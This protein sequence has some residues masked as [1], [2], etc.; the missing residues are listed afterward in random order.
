MG[1]QPVELVAAG[2][3]AGHRQREARGSKRWAQNR[4]R[5]LS[6]YCPR[7][8]WPGSG[9]FAGEEALRACRRAGS[10]LSF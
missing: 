1:S 9:P 6:G 7:P 4:R 2:G 5:L 8:G 10:A 3:H